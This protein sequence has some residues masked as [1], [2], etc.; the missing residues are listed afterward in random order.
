[1]P[2]FAAADSDAERMGVF[3]AEHA[4][5]HRYIFADAFVRQVLRVAAE[6][7]R[8]IAGVDDA[9][10]HSD[11]RAA[12]NVNAVVV[13]FHRRAVDVDSADGHPVATVQETMPKRRI[14]QFDVL[15]A[16]VFRFLEK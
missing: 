10:A 9:V 1:M 2:D 15:N 4:I 7:E 8:V 5:A 6:S 13:V 16:D 3:A 12:V 11:V 14:D